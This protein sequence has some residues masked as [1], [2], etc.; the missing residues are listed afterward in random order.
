[1]KKVS[2]PVQGK[3]Y[4]GAGLVTK[5]QFGYGYYEVQAKNTNNKGWH[6][7]FWMMAGNGE[8][9]MH[10]GK[11]LEI[12][13]AEIDTSSRKVIPSG[14]Q[15]WSGTKGYFDT[16]FAHLGSK[17]CYNNN[18]KIDLTKNF[19]TYGVN[20]REG[21]IDFYFDNIKYCQVEYKTSKYRQ[22]PVNIWLTAIGYDKNDISVNG[23][24]Q[25]YDNLKFY[26]KDQYVYSGR[27]GYSEVG[28]GWMDSKLPGFGRMPQRTTC[29]IG[30][31]ARYGPGFLQSGRYK[32]SIWKTKGKTQKVRVT[33]NSS[34]GSSV[35][36]LDFS[37]GASRWVE[38]GVFTFAASKANPNIGVSSTLLAGCQRASAVKFVRQ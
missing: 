11:F 32:V 28:R 22:D 23:S 31:T 21:F 30:E 3:N 18:T 9:T 33:V 24:P 5:H 17:R 1:M 38:L 34:S 35:K 6:N 29:S 25:Y 16:P 10:A 20:W 13:S 19:H 8:S 7:S 37:A 36:N 2:R 14:I 27:W 15:I 26:K 12:D 4:T